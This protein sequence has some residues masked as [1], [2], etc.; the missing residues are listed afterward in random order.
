MAN[1]V[2][3]LLVGI[4][5]YEGPVSQLYGCI[6]DVRGF[7]TFLRGYVP[8]ERLHLLALSNHQATRH[9]V[10][11]GFTTHLAQARPGDVAIFYY[12]GHGSREPVE[13]RFWHLE[14]TGWNQTIVCSDSRMPG[15]P[16]LA[17]KEINELIGT[18][19]ARQAHVLAILDCCHAGGATRD[20]DV[21]I[22]SAPQTETARPFEQFLPGL[23]ASWAA[24]TRDGG[25][26]NGTSSTAQPGE[27]PRHVALSA[28][29]S[30]QLSKELRIGNQYRGVFSAM[31]QQ[32]LTRLGPGA[33]YRDL[34]GA[35]SAGVRDR[36]L[37]QDPV[38]YAV[39]AE[40]L[41]QSLFGGVVRLRDH[42]VTMEHYRGHWW[43]NAGAMHGFQPPDNGH[44]TVLSVLPPDDGTAGLPRTPLG[45]I[46]ITDVQPT[47][48]Q[49]APITA[50][51]DAWLP[52]PAMRYPT[53]IVDVP[54][55]PA[56]VELQGENAGVALVRAVLT[57][58]PH[59]REDA[60]DPGIQGDRFVVIA[61]R[62]RPAM[63]L[64]LLV[65]RPDGTPLATPVNATQD[66][67]V[68][69]VRRLE[70]LAR[71]NLI[72]RLDNPG[73]SI[74]NSL[75]I[76]IVTAEPGELS[77][78]PRGTRAPLIPSRDGRVHLHYQ[79]VGLAWQKPYVWIY[80][81]NGSSRDL[82][83]T[84]LDL[85]DRYRCHSR[86][87][88]GSLIPAGATTVAFDGRPVDVSIP[89]ERLRTRGSEVFDWLKL[90][91]SEQRFEPEGFELPNLDGTVQS[92]AAMRAPGKR[93]VLDRLAD[94]VVTRDAG[95][96]SVETPE[97]TTTLV[98]LRT[99]A[100]PARETE[101]R[102]QT[103]P[104]ERGRRRG[105]P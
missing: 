72:K 60:P 22:R 6:E 11:D 7:E 43:I 42:N 47:R 17:D 37:E 73:S 28:C 48:C 63:D 82:Y 98:T 96:E 59:V 32:A 69:V 38:G 70:H 4:N 103:R 14:P 20:M 65:V 91:A 58:S 29:E 50:G 25:E 3:A 36:V 31:L 64:Q 30:L 49:V 105:H 15:I 101:E 57:G 71:W 2:Y 93:T 102:G 88:P 51:T 39:P 89:K 68:V 40:A 16:D 83:C 66:G 41:D 62:A 94:R 10:I 1:A 97:W 87:Y 104:H 46:R 74:A 95:C 67:A 81:H 76:E 13:E 23:Q 8:D 27:P 45:R 54:I 24:A 34:L 84:L 78:P 100:A 35:A 80:L 85:T 18:V 86:L 21:R 90:I 19:A 55:P 9:A 75:G 5:E 56:T 53:V 12:A 52:D 61:K 33:T 44:S 77:P 92:R 26:G 79:K 99:F